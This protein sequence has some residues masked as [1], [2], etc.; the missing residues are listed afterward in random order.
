MAP[1][2]VYVRHEY[3]DTQE[4]GN[5]APC[6]KHKLTLKGPCAVAKLP[7]MLCLCTAIFCPALPQP[8]GA[9]YTTLASVSTAALSSRA[10]LQADACGWHL[11]IDG[12]YR[13]LPVV[14]FCFVISTR[15]LYIR[16]LLGENT[17]IEF[18]LALSL[19]VLPNLLH[20]LGEDWT[21]CKVYSLKCAYVVIRLS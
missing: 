1:E 14:A 6:D 10:L 15:S 16:I 18:Q 3:S 5:D 8:G 2:I 12:G 11:G 13:K 9:C 7:P 20:S 19:K 17:T 21:R 4:D